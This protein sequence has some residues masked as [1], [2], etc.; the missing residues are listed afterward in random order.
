MVSERTKYKRYQ[1]LGLALALVGGSALGYGLKDLKP[2][3]K[4][5]S[6]IKEDGRLTK[7]VESYI[8]KFED[9][10]IT[11]PSSIRIDSADFADAKIMRAKL[12]NG[13][14][15]IKAKETIETAAN[16]SNWMIAGVIIAAS[17]VV[18]AGASYFNLR[19]PNK[20]TYSS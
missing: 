7:L 4:I 17:G 12:R 11:N 9:D 20:K 19:D 15:F 1:A 3:S 18:M 16:S 8:P 13:P 6:I 10:S 2:T 14:E 5:P